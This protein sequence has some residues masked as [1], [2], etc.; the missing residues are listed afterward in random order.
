MSRK[1]L[2]VHLL[3]SA[4]LFAAHPL[5]AIVTVGPK[6]SDP[7]HPDAGCRFQTIQEAIQYVEGYE[8]TDSPDTVD[9]YIAIAGAGFVSSPAFNGYWPGVYSEKL[10]A[11]DSG[12][13]WPG[14]PDGFKGLRIALIGGYDGYCNDTPNGSFTEIYAGNNS[15]NSVLEVG[16]T[17]A[18]YLYNLIL[19]G[20]TGVN[21][22]GGI[23]FHGR[24]ELHLT[25]VE[26]AGN[27][28]DYGAGIFAQGDDAL[29]VFLHHDTTID[30]N[31]AKHAGGGLRIQGH[32]R[33]YALEP[34]I[35]IIGNEAYPPDGDGTGGGLQVLGP[36]RADLGSV[37]ISYNSARLGGGIALNVNNTDQAVVRMFRTNPFVPVSIS[38]NTA[39]SNGGGIYNTAH[40]TDGSTPVHTPGLVCGAGYSID[41]NAAADGAALFGNDDT[42]FFDETAVSAYFD[43]LVGS[44]NDTPFCGPEPASQLGGVA[45]SAGGPC[46]SIN[47]NI[48]QTAD[49]SIV[50]VKALGAFDANFVEMRRNGASH[51]FDLND[52]RDYSVR[53]CLIA[54]NSMRGN[55]ADISGGNATLFLDACTVADNTIASGSV[56]AGDV[57]VRR[58]ILWEPGNTLFSPPAI[59]D[60]TK[61]V[62][63]NDVSTLSDDP[64]VLAVVDPG[65]VSPGTGDYH[66]LSNSPAVDYAAADS[67]SATDLDGSPRSV[68]LVSSQTP[69][70][71]GPVDLGAYELQTYTPP[72]PCAQSDK[73]FCNGFEAQP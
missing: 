24:G 21:V 72:P 28:A 68:D 32:T 1:G 42:D 45:C 53:E 11:S 60:Q 50:H 25:N 54:G 62:I 15:G 3:A 47:G 55:L 20:A 13:S 36:A 30:D 35:R 29:A 56:F 33:L 8:K 14:N 18:V 27:H 63:A 31:T 73:V 19:T 12:I 57:H 41:A 52:F 9:I 67:L 48:A 4:L 51:L 46:N 66:L 22:G 37:D 39:A 58:S 44:A 70:R 16:G 23:N 2:L 34:N 59:S 5:W 64:S 69:N 40:E 38:H 17:A 10:V 71:F 65:F 6:T 61:E 43:L 49:G 26:V 7:Q